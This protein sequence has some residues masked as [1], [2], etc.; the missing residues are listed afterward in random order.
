MYDVPC[1]CCRSLNAIRG[2]RE[3]IS[4]TAPPA[5]R[6]AE[7][8]SFVSAQRYCVRHEFSHATPPAGR[9]IVAGGEEAARAPSTGDSVYLKS[10]PIYW[11][12]LDWQLAAQ[13]IKTEGHPPVELFI[14]TSTHP[15]EPSLQQY[16]SICVFSKAFHAILIDVWNWGEDSR[17]RRESTFRIF[18]NEYD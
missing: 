5:G 2:V 7:K 17:E 8:S 3:T 4:N 9:Y 18:C 6:F 1:N 11:T 13:G 16:S 10:A 12:G 15:D 14:S